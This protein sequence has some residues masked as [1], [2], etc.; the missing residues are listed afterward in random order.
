MGVVAQTAPSDR[1]ARSGSAHG[2]RAS[3]RDVLGRSRRGGDRPPEPQQGSDHRGR[4]ARRPG[5]RPCPAVAHP[6]RD[7][8][9]P[10]CLHCPGCGAARPNGPHRWAQGLSWPRWLHA[11]SACARANPPGPLASCC[12]GSIG[13]WHCSNAGSW[14]RIRAPA[15]TPTSMTSLT[16][17]RSSSTA[18]PRDRGVSS[19]TESPSQ[20]CRSSP[21]RSN[22]CR[23]TTGTGWW[24]KVDNPINHY[25]ASPRVQPADKERRGHHAPWR[26]LPAPLASLSVTCPRTSV[27][28]CPWSDSERQL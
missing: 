17:S 22:R 12:R 5:H 21:C 19:L 18:A 6:R 20:R 3:R 10:T 25:W 2:H 14:A 23:T 8:S 15:A 7:S 27:P 4:R 28:E 16:S 1:T 26:K 24:S 11:R 9:Y 13:W